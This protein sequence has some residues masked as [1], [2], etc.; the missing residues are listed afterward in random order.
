MKYISYAESIR[1]LQA[2][3]DDQPVVF[4]GGITLNRNDSDDD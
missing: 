2:A 1:Q 3:W 4:A